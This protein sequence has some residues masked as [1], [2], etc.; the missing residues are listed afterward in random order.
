MLKIQHDDNGCWLWTGTVFLR[1]GY[2][3]FWF[4]GKSHLGHRWSYRHFVGPIPTGYQ[5]DHLCRVRNCVNPAHLEPVTP[6]ENNARSSSPSAINAVKTHCKHGHEFT[7]DNTY[8]TKK[9]QRHCK[10]CRNEIFTRRR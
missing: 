2:A 5:L 7:S 1:T 9:G 10:T 3:N 4:S 6:R 8:V